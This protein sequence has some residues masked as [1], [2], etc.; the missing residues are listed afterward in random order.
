[1]LNEVQ[2]RIDNLSKEGTGLIGQRIKDGKCVF[3]GREIVQ[4]GFCDCKKSQKTNTKI[5]KLR[6]LLEQYGYVLDLK[7]HT[8]IKLI[9]AGF[10]KKFTGMDFDD[11][12]LET[13]E[14]C[15]NLE[16]TKNYVNNALK[17]Y[18]EGVNL[19]FLG[20]FGNGKTMLMS[21]AGDEIIRK[22]GI[23]VKY[24][25]V[26][27]LSENLKKSFE[28]KEISTSKIIEDYKNAQILILDDIDKVNPSAFM[29]DLM[30]GI[31]N[32]RGDNK[33]P[34]WINGNNS[35]EDLE[36]NFYGEG[37]ISRFYD[38]SI[39]AKFTGPNWR[40]R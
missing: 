29:V 9:R 31:A 30:Y 11:Y 21:I 19:I 4:N 34:T 38:N 26:Y 15:T 8:R 12:I 27:D 1:M 39:K 22:Y 7:E 14:Q 20:N 3:C 5:K 16:I 10:P 33:L 32:Y 28:R 36:K 13:D 6:K 25:N 35:L 2:Q 17:N 37:T 18:I 23:E 40:L 24:V